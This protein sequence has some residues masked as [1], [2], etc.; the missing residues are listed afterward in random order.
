MIKI[1]S[2]KYKHYIPGQVASIWAGVPFL[3]LVIMANQGV[4]KLCVSYA[5]N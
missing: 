1:Y 5:R 3:E 4:Y 2:E